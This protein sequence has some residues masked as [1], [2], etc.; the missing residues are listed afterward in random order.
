MGFSSWLQVPPVGSRGGLFVTWKLGF[1]SELLCLDQ[2]HISCM[3][4]SDPSPCSW[5]ISCVYA[6]HTM[7]ER[8]IFWANLTSLGSSFGGPWLLLG[9][10]N[11]ILSSVDKRGGRSFGST[12]HFD[13]VDFVHSNALVDLGFVGNK[14]S[15]SNHRHGR[16]NIRER[17]DHGL[18]NQGWVHL[19]PN[20]LVNHLLA[21][22]SDHCLVLLSTNGTYR[23]IPKP[24]SFEAFWTRDQ[25]SHG[26]VV[27]AWLADVEG[28]PAFSLS[29]KWN[30]TKEALKFW[31]IHH[32]G[33]IQTQMKTLMAE[34]SGIQA[35][36]HSP[37]NVA[38]E[39][40]L[41]EALQEQLLREEVLWKQKSRELWLSCTNLNTKFFHAS[42]A[43]RKRYNSISYLSL[44]D[45]S[46]IIGRDNIGSHLVNHF[47]SLF[48]TTN[49]PIDP[50]LSDLVESVITEEEN[51]CL[52]SIPDD[53][54]IFSAISELGLNKAPG[55][56]GMTG[57][58]Y[59]S[60]WPIVKNCVIVS[61]QSFFRGGFML[62]AFNHT[63]IA[64]IPKVDNPSLVNHFRP[65]SLINFN[66]KI[67]SKILSNRLKP[68]LHKIVSPTQSAF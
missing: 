19:Y 38:R 13:F 60:Y 2:N 68:L 4:V 51:F 55:P 1:S 21:A 30:K 23:N 45:G 6:P 39:S 63:N 26:V 48:T 12:S 40:F 61:V 43:C 67:I 42:T 11:A 37:S 17:L 31:N 44:A 3:V 15:W 62:K 14:F 20:F 5:L 56:D 8:N 35:N 28:S 16:N 66:Y 50:G 57:L 33:H 46:K 36:P 18:A 32:F 53:C 7:Q 49:A 34:I 54:E 41:Q 65:V 25:S 58:F 29:R 24:F 22:N 9:D 10:F 47:T 27:G 59:K 64:L 52:C